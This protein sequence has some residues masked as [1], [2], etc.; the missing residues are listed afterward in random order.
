MASLGSKV[1]TM[2]KA[3]P[4]AG[5][6]AK[7]STMA[8]AGGFGSD[9]IPDSRTGNPAS[10]AS[11]QSISAPGIRNGGIPKTIGSEPPRGSGVGVKNPGVHTTHNENDQGDNDQ[12]GAKPSWKPAKPAGGGNYGKLVSAAAHAR[13]AARKAARPAR[14][15]KPARMTKPPVPA[16][17]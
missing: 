17:S 9:D 16:G 4:G 14:V 8:K 5:F 2:A 3:G 15:P 11:S 12:G 1:S 6:G 10:G 13:N 7:V